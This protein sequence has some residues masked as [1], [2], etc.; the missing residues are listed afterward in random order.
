MASSQGP[1]GVAIARRDMQ[2]LVEAREALPLMA[3]LDLGPTLYGEMWWVPEPTSGDYR[4]ADAEETVELTA[5]SLTLQVWSES[6]MD[7]ARLD[8]VA[9][10]IAG[11][12][13]GSST[14]STTVAP[15]ATDHLP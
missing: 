15:S 2:L 13:R 5:W 12:F 7:P 8:D 11:Q 6:G 4:A 3:E 14:T 9:T 1:A 10:A